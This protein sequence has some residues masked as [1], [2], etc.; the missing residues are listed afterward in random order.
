MQAS[1]PF[2]R[3]SLVSNKYHLAVLPQATERIRNVPDQTKI[4]SIL[5]KARSG[6]SFLLS[7]LAAQPGAFHSLPGAHDPVTEGAD[8]LVVG[9]K[10]YVDVEGR[11]MTGGEYDFILM[12]PVLLLSDIVVLN[13]REAVVVVAGES[14][15]RHHP[16]MEHDI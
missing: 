9:R 11:G 7:S 1:V 6:K 3:A 13:I 5:G 14:I 10:I 2:I 16:A 4:V 15:Y 12:I 8:M